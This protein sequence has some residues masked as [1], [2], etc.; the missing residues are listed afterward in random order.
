MGFSESK[1]EKYY[2][3]KGVNRLKKDDWN[4]VCYDEI[5]KY[6]ENKKNKSVIEYI[7]ITTDASIWDREEGNSAA[8]FRTRN[9]IVFNEDE[10]DEYKLEF[11]FTDYVK[12]DNIKVK[13]R[14]SIYSESSGK[15]LVIRLK[16]I[17]GNASFFYIEYKEASAIFKFRNSS[18]QLCR[19]IFKYPKN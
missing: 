17:S 18:Y 7:P 14:S 13:D 1:L 6:I 8:K 2:D 10:K 3:E 4:K 11:I 19:N 15:R 9:I 5:E 16:N 12:K